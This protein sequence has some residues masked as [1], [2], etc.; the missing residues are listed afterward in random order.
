MSTYDDRFGGLARLWGAEFL[1]RARRAH[2]CVIGIGGVGTW[3]VEALARSG[4]GAMTLVDLD[5]VCVTNTNRQLH[6]YEGQVGKLKVSAMAER[7][8]AINPEVLVTEVAEFFTEESAATILSTPYDYVVDAIDSVPDKCLLFV[9]CRRRNLPLI[10]SGGA[11]GKTDPTQIFCADLARSQNDSLLRSMRRQLR[12]QHGVVPDSDGLFSVPAVF[13][14]E[15]P[16]MPWDVC[17]A[18]PRPEAGGSARI[19]CATGFG[20]ASFV[21][22]AF[23]LAMAGYVVRALARGA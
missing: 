14:R 10:V 17:S 23:G 5:D 2:V 18:V 9:E 20:A 6:A 7:A 3:V 13:S 4:V 11:G 8:R 15:A 22:G 16:I 19:D 12:Q 21:T 1:Q